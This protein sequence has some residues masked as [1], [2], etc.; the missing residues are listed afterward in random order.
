MLLV[1]LSFVALWTSPGTASG[2]MGHDASAAK[3]GNVLADPYTPLRLYDGKWDLIPKSADKPSDS[4]H[5]ENRCAKVGEFFS[6]NQFV[7]GKNTALVVFLP[8]HPLE[9]G[10]YEYRNQALRVDGDSPSS[11]G[12]LEI[13]GDR[14]VYSS[15]ES[16]SGKKT[17]W[18]TTNVFSGADKIHFEVQ[19]SV[20]GTNWMTQMTGDEA[21]GK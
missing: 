16:D 11:W 15:A 18:R 1:I 13:V 14:W 6:C 19:K 8:L 20:D 9:N 5:L 4:M 2:Q 3:M 12:K 17:Y 10:G 21:R 7:N